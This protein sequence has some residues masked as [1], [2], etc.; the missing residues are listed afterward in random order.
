MSAS[1]VHEFKNEAAYLRNWF[2]MA[3]HPFGHILLAKA[4]HGPTHSQEAGKQTLLTVFLRKEDR[5]LY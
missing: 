5:V 4:N 3:Q 1:G 2:K